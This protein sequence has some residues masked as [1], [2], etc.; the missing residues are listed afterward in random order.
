MKNILTTAAPVGVALRYIGTITTTM[1][2]V[3]AML[4][5]L[6][7][8]QADQLIKMMPE[9]L[10]ALSGL[11]MIGIPVYAI[12]TKSSSD[13]GAELAKQTDAVIPPEKTIEV[14]TPS[15]VPD[16]KVAPPN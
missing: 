14:K 6:S 15:G 10:G 3:V 1:I 13:R 8:D 9:F 7:Q 12:L 11:V 2:T 5:W 16:I 4:G